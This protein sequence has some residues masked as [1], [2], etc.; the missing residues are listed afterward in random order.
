MNCTVTFRHMHSSESLREHAEKKA[1]KFMKYLI[2][3]VD[4]H[5]VMSV[6]KIRQIAEINL[7]SKNF[8]ANALEESQDMYTS[9]DK[10]M[11]KM[12]AQIRKHKEKI[13]THKVERKAYEE[14]ETAVPVSE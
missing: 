2:E 12:E 8:S 5:V 4:I 6:E 1:Q 14:L 11:S 13:K 9:I 7:M 3:P 10:V